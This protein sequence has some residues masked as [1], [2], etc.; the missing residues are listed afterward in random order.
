M[1]P[2]GYTQSQGNEGQIKGMSA[3]HEGKL[4]TERFR[5]VGD[6]AANPKL[7]FEPVSTK[8]QNLYMSLTFHQVYFCNS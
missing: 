4:R 3:Q 5:D 1:E 6:L 2:S 7:I 8:M